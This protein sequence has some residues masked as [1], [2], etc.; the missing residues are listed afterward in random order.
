MGG[1]RPIGEPEGWE[2]DGGIRRTPR[3]ATTQWGMVT[4]A[5]DPQ[6]PGGAEALATL[7]Q[8][9]WFPVYAQVRQRGYSHENAE[10]LTQ[11]FLGHLLAGD[12]IGLADRER[13][14]F[15]SFLVTSLHHFLANEKAARNAVK[16]GGRMRFVPYSEREAEGRWR[17]LASRELEPDRAFDRHWALV[18]LELVLTRLRGELVSEGRAAAFE[19]LK[20]YLTDGQPV[21]STAEV[22][23]SLGLSET[24]VRMAVHRLRQRYRVLIREEIGRTL[25]D[26]DQVEDELRALLAALR[27][28]PTAAA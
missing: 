14:R 17:D 8:I 1:S 4:A 10:D 13:G 2:P 23:R 12:R 11:A 27:D 21:L 26:P 18:V 6:A 5:G 22:G 9:Y 19:A 28:G 7:L 24:A 20:P 3:F 15:R 16:R 25:S